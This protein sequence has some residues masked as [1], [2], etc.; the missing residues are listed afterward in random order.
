MGVF[1]KF[2]S[3]DPIDM[4]LG[5]FLALLNSMGKVIYELSPKTP[6]Q[7]QLEHA[8]RELKDFKDKKAKKDL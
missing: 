4:S 6:M 8:A 1:M 5:R 2:Y 3:I 7:L